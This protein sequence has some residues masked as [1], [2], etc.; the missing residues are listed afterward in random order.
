MP[1]RLPVIGNGG[2]LDGFLDQQYLLLSSFVPNR[3]DHMPNDKEAV[4]FLETLP[5][6]K[7]LNHYIYAKNQAFVENR[8]F[9]HNK[10]R[11]NKWI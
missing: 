9:H 2:T 7:H 4:E 11:L 10:N 3:S 5:L 6:S 8:E 1:E